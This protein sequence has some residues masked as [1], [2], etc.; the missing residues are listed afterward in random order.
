MPSVARCNALQSQ[1]LTMSLWLRH[2]KYVHSVWLFNF[3]WVKRQRNDDANEW[4][5]K[6]NWRRS[7]SKTTKHINKFFQRWK[8]RLKPTLLN[9]LCSCVCSRLEP[10]W[11]WIWWFLC[12]EPFTKDSTQNKRR[13]KPSERK[14]IKLRMRW[15]HKQ[16]HF[17]KWTNGIFALAW[18]VS[19]YW[20]GIVL[21][22]F[23]LVRL[24]ILVVVF[25]SFCAFERAHMHVLTHRITKACLLFF[26][27][28]IWLHKRERTV[29]HDS[30]RSAKEICI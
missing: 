21:L 11:V 25:L 22:C 1:A 16:N 29:M 13:N 23:C 19:F 14:A 8:I 10:F 30:M 9:A 6:T 24:I 7:W 4:K 5:P 28:T 2:S 27:R 20:F 3:V 12:S 18:L 15:L 17:R 26:F